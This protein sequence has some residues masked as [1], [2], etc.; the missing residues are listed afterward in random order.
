M[1]RADVVDLAG[2]VFLA[3]DQAFEGGDVVHKK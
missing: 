2:L 3:A 1:V